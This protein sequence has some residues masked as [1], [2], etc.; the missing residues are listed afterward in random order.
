MQGFGGLYTYVK[1]IF[2]QI[3]TSAF[4]MILLAPENEECRQFCAEKD[5]TY[6]TIEI[7][8]GLSVVKDWRALFTMKRYIKKLSPD[9]VHAHSAKGGF[10]GRIASKWTKVPS[11]YTPHGI[12]YLGFT[13]LKRLLFFGL[14]VFAK[15]YTNYVLACSESER[16]RCAWEVGINSSKIAVLP[17]SIP[18]ELSYEERTVRSFEPQ[19]RLHIGVIARLTYQKNPLLFVQVAHHLLEKYPWATFSILGAGLHDHQ[20]V[21]VEE[22]IEQYGLRSRFTIYQWGSFPSARDYLRT[23]DVFMMTSVFEGLPFSLLEAMD[24]GILCVTSKCDG[25]NDVIQHGSNGFACMTTGEF[26]DAISAVVESS[27]LYQKITQQAYRDLGT[28]YSLG[29]FVGSLQSYYTSR[30]KQFWY[31]GGINA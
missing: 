29:R 5:I 27:G 30:V 4:E 26:V 12:S 6:E 3:D 11:I 13:G 18:V 19:K 31:G 8:R 25:C 16:I 24:E 2:E 1:Q 9:I 17:N 28:S 20:K 23:L 15:R 10:L 14:E 21:E 22:L 7:E